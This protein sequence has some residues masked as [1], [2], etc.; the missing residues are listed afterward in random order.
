M[1]KFVSR[2][3]KKDFYL[4]YTLVFGVISFFIYYQFAGNGKSLVWSHDGIPQHLNS[5][6]YYGRYLRE[7]LHTIF[8]EHK[9]ELP[10][11]DMNIGYGSDILTTLHYY[12]IGDPLTLLS[13]FV[14]ADKT[15]VLYEVLIFLRIYL[16]GISFSVF[17][18]YHK[19]PK[20]ATFMGTLIYIF[21]GWTIYA[22][23]KHPYFSNPMIYLPL[24]LMG[25]DKIYKR[26]K[27]WLF[28][29]ATAVSAMSNFYFF[30]MICIFMFI[31][32]VFRYFGIFSRRSVKDVLVWL[33]KFI[34]YYAVSLMIAAVIFLPVIMTLFGTDRF[35]AENYVPLLYDRIYYEKYLG[36]LIGENM[37]QWGVAGYSAV[38]MAGVF[39][40]VPPERGGNERGVYLT[41]K[42]LGEVQLAKA[43]IAAGIQMLMERLGITE[44]DIC[45]VYIAGAFGNYMDPVSAGKIG[46]FPATL[47]KKVKP[48]GNAA[49]E[50]AKIAL[51]N[52]KEM[53]EMDELVRKIEFVELAASADFQ[54]HFID[55]LGFETGE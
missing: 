53:L 15:E 27:P 29:W 50:G 26:E 7:V 36:D 4:L 40:L 18:F 6:A 45:S 23:M 51:V 2:D 21:A 24:V 16:A 55:E 32:A 47:V 12:V 42:D 20:Q 46:L 41:Q 37:I 52:E 3:S 9:L 25:I 38:A 35:Q 34:G 22:A 33:V 17:C 31:Y 54:D 49:G 28:I 43:A 48:V 14:P 10:M 11:W 1:R 5:L 39:I 19:N 30:Y 13:V 8:V 44:D